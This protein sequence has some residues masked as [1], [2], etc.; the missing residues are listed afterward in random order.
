MFVFVCE[1]VM[2]AIDARLF[3]RV[4]LNLG[5]PD[6]RDA[7]GVFP[8]APPAQLASALT[9]HAVLLFLLIPLAE[10]AV[11][12]FLIVRNAMGPYPLKRVAAR[13][14]HPQDGVVPECIGNAQQFHDESHFFVLQ[15]TLQTQQ[16]IFEPVL[17]LAATPKSSK[18]TMNLEIEAVESWEGCNDN[19]H[20]DVS[21]YA[22]KP[23]VGGLHEHNV[24]LVERWF[25][26]RA[27]DRTR[28]AI[29]CVCFAAEHVIEVVERLCTPA[30]GES[31]IRSLDNKVF[32][33]VYQAFVRQYDYQVYI[34]SIADSMLHLLIVV[35]IPFRDLRLL[36]EMA[37]MH[38]LGKSDDALLG[39]Y[40]EEGPYSFHKTCADVFQS[41]RTSASADNK[42]PGARDAKFFVKLNCYSSKHDYGV[43]PVDCVTD[44]VLH[45]SRGRRFLAA[46]ARPEQ[47]TFDL[48][49]FLVLV[50][51][52]EGIK[53]REEFRIFIRHR[54]LVGISQQCWWIDFCF[55]DNTLRGIACAIHEWCGRLAEKLPFPD[56]VVD[57]L[58]RD[59]A[60]GEPRCYPIEC[61]PYGAFSSSGSA[62]FSWKKDAALLD[63]LPDPL[64]PD[65]LPETTVFRV[66]RPTQ[67]VG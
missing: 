47:V 16:P 15:E 7:V 27:M 1:F 2:S 51:W 67:Q 4:L 58:V 39:H 24:L 3:G 62:L 14:L 49:L 23:L 41:A 38:S 26:E 33:D 13:N 64:D 32:H 22:V 42:I 57:V 35:G 52:I 40:Q 65:H 48:D 18:K 50:P 20:H 9:V 53:E 46:F 8:C 59:G 29:R 6:S 37:T 60:D 54:R 63:V 44:L 28:D 36:K 11:N 66:L 10:S 30:A 45:L 55:G 12:P 43:V 21:P 61:N 31:L 56:A 17:E 5:P 19:N 25:W 34:D